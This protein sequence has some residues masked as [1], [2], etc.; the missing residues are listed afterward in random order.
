MKNF[1]ILFFFFNVKEFEIFG[2]RNVHGGKFR[3]YRGSK[4]EVKTLMQ[5]ILFLNLHNEWNTKKLYFDNYSF[6]I[7]YYKNKLSREKSDRQ[8]WGTNIRIPVYLS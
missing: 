3:S 8:R 5:V 4:L 6:L 1:S 7:Y 2:F